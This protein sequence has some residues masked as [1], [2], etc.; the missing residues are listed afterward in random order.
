MKMRV[1]I[2]HATNFTVEP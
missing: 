2:S 1:Y